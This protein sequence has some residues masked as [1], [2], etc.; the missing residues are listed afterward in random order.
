[1]LDDMHGREPQMAVTTATDTSAADTAGSQHGLL[2]RIGTATIGDDRVIT[3]PYGPRPLVYADHTASGRSLSFIEDFIRA[4]VLPWYANTHTDASDTG[5]RTSQLREDA[6]QIVLDALGGGPEHALIFCGSGATGA[7][8]KMLRILGMHEAAE[9]ARPVVFVGPYEH[10]SNE[11]LWRESEAD[12]VRI[13]ADAS[14]GID[15]ADLERELARYPDRPLRIG[16]FSAGSNVTGMLADTD[17]ISDLLH[18]YDALACWDFAAAA[19]HM[20]VALNGTG[21]FPQGYKD[22][23]F[24]SPHKFLGGPGTPGVLAV[25]RDLVDNAVPT[26]P[27]GGTVSYVYTGARHY[28]DDEAHREE[29]GTPAIVESIRA[30][31][32]FHLHRTVGIETI[33]ER[34]AG[35]VRRA[36]ASW[37]TNRAIEVLGDLDGARLPI[38]SFLVHGPGGRLMHHNLVVALLN[39]LFGIQCRGGCS[40]AGPYGHDLLRI[41]PHRA[42]DLASRAVDGWLGVRPGWTRVSFTYHLT[43]EVFQ[44]IV[45][46]VHLIA[47]YG[48]RV[49]AQY[50]FDPHSGLW[51]HRVRPPMAPGLSALTYD[52]AGSLCHP[53]SG[54]ATRTDESFDACLRD[55]IAILTAEAP[56]TDESRSATESGSTTVPI[57]EAFERLRWFHLPPDCVA[58]L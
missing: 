15:A 22:A 36:I 17:A 51:S 2:R 43:E 21:R 32:V 1:L 58:A 55:A 37:R 26:V 24:L 48:P 7:I 3:G 6:R 33:M 4:E 52:A 53:G 19:P 14:G 54:L 40:C 10:H 11:L 13:R 45:A 5:R 18:R 23:V 35:F 46:A 42:H 44:Y 38:V 30:G 12:V 39:D 28:I 41:G 25:R 57:P 34:E 49:V 47:T 29:A 56:P 20:P 31:L 9:I 50:R 8:D 16:S 27:G